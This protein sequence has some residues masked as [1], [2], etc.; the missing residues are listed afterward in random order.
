MFCPPSNHLETPASLHFIINLS[1]P[2]KVRGTK[3]K[4]Y[5]TYHVQY[6]TDSISICLFIF[7][8]LFVLGLIVILH[9]S[10]S[11]TIHRQH[12]SVDPF[13]LFAREETHGVSDIQ[14]VATSVEWRGIGS[15]L[16]EEKE[17][18]LA[19]GK[20]RRCIRLS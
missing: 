20:S 2:Q 11:T 19:S 15:G 8:F 9:K 17:K 7:F 6:A 16:G 14:R 12:F 4:R 10:S 1:I 18:K 13:R 3:S 5:K